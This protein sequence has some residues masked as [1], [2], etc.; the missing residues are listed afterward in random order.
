[1]NIQHLRYFLAV[2]EKGSITS[3]AE[4]LR[5]SQPSLSRQIR[6]FEDD[7]GSPLFERGARSI[8]LNQRGR[9]IRD[10]GLKLIKQ[11]DAS[12][13]KIRRAAEAEVIRIGYA[14]SLGGE[15]LQKAIARFSQCHPQILVEMHDST[16]TE[17]HDG[18]KAEDF[19]LCIS[20]SNQDQGVTWQQLLE[21]PLA[22]AVLKTH[23]LLADKSNRRL[24]KIEELRDERFLFFSRV[25]YPSAW[26]KTAGYFQA[27]EVNVKIAGEF[28]GIS[29]LS[30]ALEAGLG[31]AIVTANT[32]LPESIKLLK[33]KPEP[34]PICVAVGWNSHKSLNPIKQEFVNEL[35]RAAKDSL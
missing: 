24:V 23:T 11:I 35:M 10:E 8:Q 2:V 14:P 17:L 1:M 18:L 34:N 19:D 28:D 9:E 27:N 32:R 25:D 30:L 20:E 15:I 21:R 22:L 16:G 6:A 13:R 4:T 5:I 33:L 29:S 31:L 3:A 7:L 12:I 26:E